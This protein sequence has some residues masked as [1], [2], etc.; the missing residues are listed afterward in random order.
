MRIVIDTREQCPL[1]FTGYDCLVE[2]GG[3]PTGD[4]SLAGL[5]DRVAAERKS[6]DDLIA[7]LMGDNRQ[8]FER[9][10]A[11]GRGYD[12]FA[13]VIEASWEQLAKGM[14]RSRMK[15]HSAAQS[16]LAFQVRYGVPFI[17]TGSRPASAYVIYSLFEKY[18]TEQRNR[19]K[20]L[21]DAVGA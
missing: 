14:Y 9:E 6:L 21:A 20:A 10:L 1:D 17:F 18:V 4:Y 15:P 2:R 19:L 8:R 16:V 7:C 12:L 5:T 11:R 13:V 3:L